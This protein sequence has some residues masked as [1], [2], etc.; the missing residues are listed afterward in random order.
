MGQ[1]FCRQAIHQKEAFE[2]TK[3]CL[4]EECEMKYRFRVFI[5]ALLGAFAMVGAMLAGVLNGGVALALPLAGVGTFTIE[6]SQIN[7]T[8]FRLLPRIGQLSS[9]GSNVP[10]TQV[11]LDCTI[12]NLKLYKDVPVPGGG[13]IRVLIQTNKE[14]HANGMV[15]NMAAL[16]ALAAFKQL[17]I[18]QNGEAS[19]A[20]QEFSL[21]ATQ[22]TLVIPHIQTT[23]LYTN[24]ITLPGL[25]VSVSPT[26]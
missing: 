13:K 12:E 26:H 1:G 9:D 22:L 25:S 19:S 21:S 10:E 24:S 8:H 14:V 15:M 18:G 6:A 11:S 20:V 2:R 7:I 5:G 16:Q 23:Y 17:T 4:R 3:W